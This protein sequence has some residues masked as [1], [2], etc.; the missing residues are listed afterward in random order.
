[1][2]EFCRPGDAGAPKCRKE[3]V[4]DDVPG[5][6]SGMPACG[7]SNAAMSGGGVATCRQGVQ[8][9]DRRCL[10]EGNVYTGS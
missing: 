8:G 3:G 7:S 5:A 9:L 10:G 2:P 6:V 1:M 4:E